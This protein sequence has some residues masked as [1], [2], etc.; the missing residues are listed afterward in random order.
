MYLRLFEDTR[1]SDR[2]IV[3]MPCSTCSSKLG[4]P[5]RV[6]PGR[7]AAD[8]GHKALMP[9]VTDIQNQVMHILFACL[10]MSW[11]EGLTWR[12][13]KIVYKHS[14][15]STAVF[16]RIPGACAPIAINHRAIVRQT[17]FHWTLPAE[18]DCGR[19]RSG[20]STPTTARCISGSGARCCD[21]IAVLLSRNLLT[22]SG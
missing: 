4:R 17:L 2:R 10:R 19:E 14:S 21:Y 16:F 8:N 22:S 15:G 12:T 1:V 6:G 9:V 13:D 18:C 7:G 20:I 5:W 11:L 3:R